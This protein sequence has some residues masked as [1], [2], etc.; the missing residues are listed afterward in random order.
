MDGHIVFDGTDYTLIRLFADLVP[1]MPEKIL[2][3]DVDIMFNRDIT[4]LYDTDIENVEYAAA[5]DH[6]GK[7]LIRPDYI[8]AGV[9]LFN[10]KKCRETG[11]FEKARN[12]IKTKKMD[13]R[14]PGCLVAQYYG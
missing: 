12:Q 10:M 6:Y 3:L 8:N 14:R 5:P 13:F 7:Y 9:I 11:I 1:K 4:L 2:Y